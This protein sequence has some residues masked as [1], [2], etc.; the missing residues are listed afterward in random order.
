MGGSWRAVYVR[1]MPGSF[2]SAHA[3][4]ERQK[5]REAPHRREGSEG[6]N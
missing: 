4:G 2:L 6:T 3:A 5:Q 1:M